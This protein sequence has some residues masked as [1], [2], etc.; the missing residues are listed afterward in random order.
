MKR[1]FITALLSIAA[2]GSAAAADLPQPAPVQARQQSV[3]ARALPYRLA[4]V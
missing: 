3:G 1:L 2:A 4:S